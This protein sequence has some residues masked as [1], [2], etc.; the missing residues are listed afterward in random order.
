MTMQVHWIPLR[1]AKRFIAR[2]HRHLRQIQGAIIALGLWVDGE[3]RGVTLIG[4]GAR[5]D[6]PDVAVITRLCTDGCRNG[7][8]KLYAK[9][10]RLSQALGFVGIKTFTRE[11]E[12]GSSLFAVEAQSSGI[13]PGRH[14]DRPSRPRQ[15]GDKAPKRRWQ[16]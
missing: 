8:S 7:C 2:H 16:L 5:M 14:W 1:D 9:A 4:R 3:L 12:S 13:T 10:K 6:R 11:N 15:L